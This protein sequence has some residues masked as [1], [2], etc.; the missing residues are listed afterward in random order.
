[1]KKISI[2]M[3]LILVC[4]LCHSVKAEEIEFDGK[5]PPQDIIELQEKQQEEQISLEEI[6]NMS[7][8]E[9]KALGL[10]PL[11]PD[12]KVLLNLD[13]RREQGSSRVQTSANYEIIIPTVI[14]CE[15]YYCGPAS[16]LMALDAAGCYA[17]VAG[18]NQSQK[19]HTLAGSTYLNTDNLGG[20]WTATIAVVMNS[21]TG[22]NRSWTSSMVTNS[23]QY[24]NLSYWTR[25]NIVGGDAVVYCMDMENMS[26]YNG[27]MYGT[28]FI[29]GTGINYQNTTLIFT[30]FD[31]V[32]VKVQ[33]PNY[34]SNFSGVYVAFEDLM[35]AMHDFYSNNNF[36]Y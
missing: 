14:Q 19:Q 9:L 34:N 8:E 30:D 26:Y 10:L 12:E 16:T 7:P 27:Q 35:Y 6:A 13:S 28:H 1:M 18:M 25:T 11:S 2:V 5:N 36:V 32:I 4:I 17:S 23:S 21:F 20:T 31:Q 15:T 24:L 3:C 22:R 29:A 33:D